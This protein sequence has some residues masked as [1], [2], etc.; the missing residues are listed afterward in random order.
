MTR[1]LA[2]DIG[3]T[4]IRAAV[5][6]SEGVIADELNSRIELGDRLIT[7][8]ELIGRLSGF[9]GG[10]IET[11]TGIQ[12][13]GIGFPGFFE[14]D[15]GLLTA[16]P[17]LP[18]LK[19]V[20]L[21]SS[22]S[23]RLNLPVRIQN[24]AVCAALGEHRFGAGKDSRNLLHITLGTGIGGGLILGNTPFTGDGGMA[25]E[26]GHLRVVRG[27]EARR[28]G[29]GGMG[30]VEAHA[31]ATAIAGRYTEASGTRTDARGVHRRALDG[32]TTAG[33][34]IETAGGYLGMAIAEA[35]KLLDVHTV[36]ISGGLT[37]AWA[38]L[39]PPM[40]DAL[41][42]DLIPPLKNRI[43]V[44]ASTLNDNAGLLG[45]AA[46]ATSER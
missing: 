36:T 37:G 21:A 44:L 3:G 23:D 17:N 39:Y 34:I 38:M 45:A 33:V 12:A 18:N 41:N 35:L 20:R 32:D 46:L 28:C 4:N 26:I 9:F 43:R 1:V 11:A 5:V 25:M 14:G 27:N 7:E 2:A 19:N 30:C 24:D 31:S 6:D 13:V 8:D 22:L 40:L 29:C 15:S 42:S 16:S 10:I